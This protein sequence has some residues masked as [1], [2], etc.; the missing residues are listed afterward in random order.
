[1]IGFKPFNDI[2]LRILVSKGGTNEKINKMV[3]RFDHF[4]GFFIRIGSN[5]LERD[6]HWPLA[7]WTL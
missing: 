4:G 5:K 7:R 2:N 6:P 1:M 3:L